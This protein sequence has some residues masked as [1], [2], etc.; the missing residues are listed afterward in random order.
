MDKHPALLNSDLFDVLHSYLCKGEK[1]KVIASRYSNKDRFNT[2]G[3]VSR[4]VNGNG[5]RVH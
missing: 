1:Q 5:F 2:S 4:E 3:K